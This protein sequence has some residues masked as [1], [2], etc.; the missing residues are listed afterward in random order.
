V[1]NLSGGEWANIF[2]YLII[3]SSI[4]ASI[5]I[6]TTGDRQQ[7]VKQLLMWFMVLF[8]ISFIYNNKDFFYNFVPYKAKINEEERK[9][10]L[11]RTT[12]GHFYIIIT[13]N[14]K[15]ILFLIDTGATVTSL[16]KKD[17][18]RV[19][20]DVDNLSYDVKT[21]TAS[22]VSY[23]AS[24]KLQNIKINNLIFDDMWAMVNGNNVD[25]SLLGMNFLNRLKKYNVEKDRMILY[26]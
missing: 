24:I 14:N 11:Q 6:R 5:F 10:E 17:A 23:N 25:T 22:G 2:Y 8:V 3:I 20:I 9:I 7:K 13:I 15:N 4:C 12:D 19:G 1:F 21:N 18:K 16:S 26:Y